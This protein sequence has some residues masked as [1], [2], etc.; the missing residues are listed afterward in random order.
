MGRTLVANR[1]LAGSACGKRHRGGPL[2]AIVRQQPMRG[3]LAARVMSAAVLAGCSVLEM[4]TPEAQ[5]EYFVRHLNSYVG[6]PL[7]FENAWM[8][9]SLKLTE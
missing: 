6:R 1:L 7:N 5:H 9:P 8:R 2:N 4:S 3:K